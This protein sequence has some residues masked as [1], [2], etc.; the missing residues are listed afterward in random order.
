MVIIL[1]I[2]RVGI[3]NF[4]FIFQIYSNKFKFIRMI[5]IPGSGSTK[6]EI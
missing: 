4:K 5:L 2:N 3:A 6:L 1:F